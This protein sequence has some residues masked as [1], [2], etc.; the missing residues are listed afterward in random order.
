MDRRWRRPVHLAR[1]AHSLCAGRTDGRLSGDATAISVRGSALAW[2]FDVQIGQAGRYQLEAT[3]HVD[4]KPLATAQNAAWLE[5]GQRQL[6]LGFDST[7]FEGKTPKSF[8]LRDLRLVDQGQLVTLE[9]R[10]LAL[11]SKDR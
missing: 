5:A 7:L 4:G 6:Q 9:R 8:E 3:L 11:A 1:C 2:E 10:A